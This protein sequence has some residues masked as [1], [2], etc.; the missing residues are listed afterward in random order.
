VV[1]DVVV[2]TVVDDVLVGVDVV[3]V[4]VD[5]LLVLVDVVGI[6]PRPFDDRLVLPAAHGAVS[7][8]TVAIATADVTIAVL[9]I[10]RELSGSRGGTFRIPPCHEPEP[11]RGS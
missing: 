1:V 11:G 9:G 7:A 8:S 10:R 3:D 6:G 4:L 5:V 2:L